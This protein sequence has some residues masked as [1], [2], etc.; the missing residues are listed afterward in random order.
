M[1]LFGQIFPTNKISP[2]RKNNVRWVARAHHLHSS[3]ELV[4]RKVILP[5]R[6]QHKLSVGIECTWQLVHAQIKDEEFQSGGI[7]QEKDQELRM[8]YSVAIIR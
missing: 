1:E 3:P 4:K 5:C 8:M 2:N 6:A 7:L